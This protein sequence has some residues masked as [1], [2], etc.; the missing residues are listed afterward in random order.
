MR[1][2]EDEEGLAKY[3]RVHSAQGIHNEF[4]DGEDDQQ[5]EEEGLE[6]PHGGIPEGQHQLYGQ[7]HEQYDED[8]VDEGEDP[9]EGDDPVNEGEEP[10]DEDDDE[11][12]YLRQAHQRQA[13]Q[14][15]GRGYQP[16][17]Q[18]RDSKTSSQVKSKEVSRVSEGGKGREEPSYPSEEQYEQYEE[19]P[20]E[21]E[22]Y[23]EEQYE[24]EPSH[25]QVKEELTKTANQKRVEDLFNKPSQP[26]KN[27]VSRSFEADARRGYEQ[28]DPDQE[29]DMYDQDEEVE[30][31]D[32][33]NFRMANIDREIAKQ[34]RLYMD[35][36]AQAEA[37]HEH[38]AGHKHSEIEEK[39]EIDYYEKDP[40]NY[41][42]IMENLYDVPGHE[43]EPQEGD[44]QPEQDQEGEYEDQEGEYD[45]QEAYE[46]DPNDQNGIFS[47]IANLTNFFFLQ[48]I[49]RFSRE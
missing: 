40:I 19:E 39:D 26:K 38:D 20:L 12:A 32:E 42:R 11:M 18:S 4:E 28:E 43:H 34:D 2:S 14:A 30:I 13:E 21:D 16:Q 7:H 8:P 1:D 31:D 3:N 25:K 29:E 41:N 17:D 5:G 37:G 15:L 36:K 6:Q 23:E 48:P 49:R 24:E 46:E 44:E 45:D 9:N 22:Q 47:D 35:L 33:G 10:G 27:Y